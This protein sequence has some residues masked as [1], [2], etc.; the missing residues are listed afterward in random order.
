VGFNFG[1]AHNVALHCPDTISVLILF[2]HLVI[3]KSLRALSL[4]LYKIC[5]SYLLIRATFLT[6][7]NF[8]NIKQTVG[9]LAS[10]L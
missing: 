6:N 8:Q 10:N 3:D 9:L 2:C 1:P 5:I 4:K 7:L